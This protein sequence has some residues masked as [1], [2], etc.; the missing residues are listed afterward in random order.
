MFRVGSANRSA[1]S[2]QLYLHLHFSFFAKTVEP[3]DGGIYRDIYRDIQLHRSC[4]ATNTWIDEESCSLPAR[5]VLAARESFW[6][7][8]ICFRTDICYMLSADLRPTKRSFPLM[9]AML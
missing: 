5:T 3:F 4:I 6:L 9:P 1:V 7:V 2:A 8:W